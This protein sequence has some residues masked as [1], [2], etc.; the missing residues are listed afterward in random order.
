MDTLQKK[1]TD[2]VQYSLS[3]IHSI[4]RVYLF[5]FTMLSVCQSVLR[6]IAGGPVNGGWVG[7]D[8]EWIADSCP[9]WDTGMWDGGKPG[10]F[11]VTVVTY[12][13][14]PTGG[15]HASVTFISC[16]QNPVNKYLL[17]FSRSKFSWAA[18]WFVIMGNNTSNINNILFWHHALM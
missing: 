13:L 17:P 8:L 15:N 16:Y 14:L 10:R 1:S 12:S 4:Y 11:L 2:S 7:E 6:Q 9:V 3:I 5:N 18:P